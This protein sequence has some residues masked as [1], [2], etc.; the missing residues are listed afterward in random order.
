[1]SQP[2]LRVFSL[3]MLALVC[4]A[5]GD[6]E[7]DRRGDATAQAFD[8]QEQ[9]WRDQR[10][11]S[12]SRP[13]GWT[14]LV[15]LHWI[16]PGEHYFGSDADNGIRLAMGPAHAGMLSRK[17]DR[18]RVVPE[19]GAAL[20]LDGQPLKSGAP[21]LADTDEK[22]PSVL[23]FDGGKGTIT[24]IR[25][26]DRYALR[27]KHADAPTR[28]GFKGIDYWPGGEDWIVT[29]RFVP[30]APGK[31]LPIANIVGTVEDVPN[32]GAME[33]E[34]DGQVFRIEALDEGEDTLFLVFADRTSGKGSYPAGRFIDAPRPDAQGNVVIDFNRAYNPPCVFTA[35]ATCPL[36]P[37]ENRLDL[38]I[39]AGEKAYHFEEPELERKAS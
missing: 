21:L 3:V 8:A 19:R 31:T 38:E 39:T 30:N 37:P 4:A 33:F 36:P 20:T 26:G 16:E 13:D 7:A 27:V 14:S 25:R 2:S 17:G 11:A 9:A 22:G 10:K 18:F 34:R 29:A 35:F 6:R 32:P 28:T 15:G 1:M 23:G 24:V 12:L 5:C